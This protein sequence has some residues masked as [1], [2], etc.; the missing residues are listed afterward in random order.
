MAKLQSRPRLLSA[1]VLLTSLLCAPAVLAQ[2][3]PPTK[4]DS[5][6][7]EAKFRVIERF[8]SGSDD[9]GEGRDAQSGSHAG[10]RIPAEL[11]S[12]LETDDWGRARRLLD[13]NLESRT[14]SDPLVTFLD[15]Y[16]AYRRGEHGRAL[17]RLAEAADELTD[18]HDYAS[19]L[20]ARAALEAGKP[21]R[22]V[23]MAAQIPASSLKY[24]DG[25]ALL[26]RGLLDAGTSTDMKRALRVM[27]TYLE[28]FAGD[29]TLQMTFRIGETL[30]GRGDW[31]AAGA[32]FLRVLR[33]SPLSDEAER[34]RAIMKAHL[35]EFPDEYARAIEDPPRDL[36]MA[37]FEAHFEAHN[38]ETVVRELS[39][40]VDDWTP[41][42]PARCKALYWVAKSYTKM[43]K[44]RKASKWYGKI[45]KECEGIQPWERNA[46]YMGGKGHWNVGERERALELFER[47]WTKFGDHS[48][49]DDAHY[50]AARIHRE[51]DDGE[52]AEKVL[53]QQVERYP[54]GDMA[55]NAHWLLVREMIGR[56]NWQ[57]VVG[58]VDGLERTGE[59]D[60]YTKGRL[61]YFRARAHQT[62][63]QTEKARAGFRAVT[64]D[65]PM[66]YY[67]LLAA[68]RLV[69]LS[70]SIAEACAKQQERKKHPK[71][72]GFCSRDGSRTHSP[73]IPDA[74]GESPRFRKGTLLLEVGLRD[75][76][77]GEFK[78]L[79]RDF[80][81]RDDAL[82]AL[83]D[84]LDRSGAYPLAHRLPDRIGGWKDTYPTE[85]TRRIW[86][87]AY[88]KAFPQV[89]K[90][91]ADRRDLPRGLVW[92]IMRKESGFAPRIKSWAGARGLMQLM[93]KTADMVAGKEGMGD[94][95]PY[96]LLEPDINVRLGTAYMKS[97]AGKGDGHPALIAAGYNGGWGNVSRWLRK[98]GE[99]PLDLWIEDIPYGQTRHYA[100][101]VLAYWW[102][103]ERLYDG[104]RVPELDFALK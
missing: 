26:A 87:I 103:Y 67:G 43:R 33:D 51:E 71:N 32:H 70:G 79:F 47:L 88:P 64:A 37:Y 35:D 83:A 86:Q 85:K 80:S 24:P 91:W 1:V 59:D 100:K 40:A 14:K 4:L 48:F 54:T 66:S 17:E 92:A 7:D 57:K 39:E 73:K 63:G 45:L 60:P 5:A 84:L 62:L 12:A 2:S 61:H 6:G 58:Y 21:H 46:L 65:Y 29:A 50:F 90:K 96:E 53:R 25:L 104:T 68:N 10:S 75:L 27:R 11:R 56:G 76:A 77:R 89:V 81:G 15:G 78:A 72:A 20:G 41:G 18:L 55:E 69:D 13:S 34:V 82:A 49:A 101:M 74:M 98:R 99:L 9:E 38:S 52:A 36:R 44:H 97:L 95:G 94:V 42:T 31:E 23:L 3:E 8:P 93:P 22:A 28:K 16:V 30:V 19:Y 102:A